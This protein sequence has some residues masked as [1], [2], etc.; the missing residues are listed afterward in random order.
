MFFD[1]H[2]LVV[3][4]CELRNV[5]AGVGMDLTY[6]KKVQ[7]SRKCASE[8]IEINVSRDVAEFATSVSWS[9]LQIEFL[10]SAR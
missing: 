7:T 8:T 6:S 1:G 10:L 3:S 4:A 9:A 2:Q 5:P